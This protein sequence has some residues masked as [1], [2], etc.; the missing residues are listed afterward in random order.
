MRLLYASNGNDLLSAAWVMNERT[1][2]HIKKAKQSMTCDRY[3]YV[4]CVCGKFRYIMI[5]LLEIN[6]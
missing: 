2:E 4:L 5:G 3:V 6:L 1:S